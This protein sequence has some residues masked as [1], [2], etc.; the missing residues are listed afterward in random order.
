MTG[1][2]STLDMNREL[3]LLRHAKSDW[4]VD[5][6]DFD[7]PLSR[8]GK[9]AA[10]QMGIW[11]KQHQLLPD[12]VVSSPALRA[13][14]TAEIVC[15]ALGL[16]A[17]VIHRDKRLYEQDPDGLKDTLAECPV[18]AERV[19]LTGHN[20]ELEALLIDL[21]GKAALPDK[22]KLL[23]TAALARLII[24][25]DWSRLNTGCAE[26]LSITYARNLPKAR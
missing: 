1:R 21:A 18:Q 17:Q 3:W 15:A 4:H 10:R 5:A 11:M 23:P 14:A 2:R 9:R 20:P 25:C 26:L 12:F 13:V 7:R 19:L 16:P 24:S 22:D 6:D 8:R